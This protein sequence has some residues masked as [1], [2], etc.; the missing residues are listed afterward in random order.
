MHT[1]GEWRR[2]LWR[3]VLQNQR[4]LWLLGL[5]LCG[6]QIGCLV[7]QA[8]WRP[9]G[10][11]LSGLLSPTPL[12]GGLGSALRHWI[13]YAG[14]HFLLLL[15]LFM[16]GFS[17]CGV[18]LALVVPV[19]FGAGIGLS[20][21]YHFAQGPMGVGYVALIVL[22]PALLTATALLTACAESVRF[23]AKLCRVVL[24]HPTIGSSLWLDFKLYLA[25]FLLC[26]GLLTAAGVLDTVLRLIFIHHFV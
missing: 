26:V 18:P 13:S 14:P 10:A 2:N 21:A 24:P 22:P 1:P 3:F 19:F 4:L 11:A 9:L 17:V 8:A 5:F 7:F 12:G 23:S 20:E 6:V 25:R 16:F 15:L